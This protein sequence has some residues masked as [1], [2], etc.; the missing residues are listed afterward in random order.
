MVVSLICPNGKAVTH[1]VKGV[2]YHTVRSDV[3]GLRR[4]R[5][6]AEAPVETWDTLLAKGLVGEDCDFDEISDELKAVLR[7]KGLISTMSIPGTFVLQVTPE[8]DE[9]L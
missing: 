7:P 9:K 6:Y 5:F 1:K 4:V 2:T 8:P 3:S